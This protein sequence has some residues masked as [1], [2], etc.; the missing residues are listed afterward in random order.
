MVK[1]IFALTVI[2][3]SILSVHN[4]GQSSKTI[5][6]NQQHALTNR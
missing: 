4:Q 2:Q 3:Y 1:I 5:S 6:K